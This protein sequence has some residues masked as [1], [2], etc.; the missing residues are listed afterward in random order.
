VDVQ[1]ALATP[2]IIGDNIDCTVNY[3]PL[4][5]EIRLIGKTGSRKLLEAFAVEIAELCFTRLA[6]SHVTV[7][8]RKP[9]KVPGCDAV[10][11]RRTFSRN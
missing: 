3:G 8:V 7:E 6:V 4:A 5:N 2:G 11:V 1:C 9:K 10:G